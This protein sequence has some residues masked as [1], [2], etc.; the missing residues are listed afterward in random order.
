MM[1]VFRCDI[2][3]QVNN[4]LFRSRCQLL[5]REMPRASCGRRPRDSSRQTTPI[6]SFPFIRE[7]SIFRKC[8]LSQVTQITVPAHSLGKIFQCKLSY[9][10]GNGTIGRTT[11]VKAG[12]K[13]LDVR[14]QTNVVSLPTIR[15]PL[16]GLN[17]GITR[18]G[19]AG[20]RFCE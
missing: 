4:S 16:D 9:V 5:I 18:V 12:P 6:S 1:A 11:L 2:T 7:T 17:D 13:Y 20:R 3:L 19:Q 10:L 8:R 14:F 15:F